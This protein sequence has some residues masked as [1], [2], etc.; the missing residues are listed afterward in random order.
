MSRQ[1]GSVEQEVLSI[2]VTWPKG[3]RRP[4]SNRGDRASVPRSADGREVLQ[5][6][7]EETAPPPPCVPKTRRRRSSEEDTKAG[8][9]FAYTLEECKW[10]PG[11][12]CFSP[13]LP[14]QH[15]PTQRRDLCLKLVSADP[16]PETP[17]T[18]QRVNQALAPS[19]E[20]LTSCWWRESGAEDF[21]SKGS[22]ND[23]K[24]QAWKVPEKPIF[25]VSGESSAGPHRC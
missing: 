13:S 24:P 16:S 7:Q 6:A 5:D 14:R 10:N 9:R 8:S 21:S 17:L 1:P 12:S 4:A 2:K 22:W 23:T 11:R 20:T 18:A 15:V 19:R 25:S 3:S